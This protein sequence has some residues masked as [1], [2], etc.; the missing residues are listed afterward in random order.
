MS[1]N[2]IEKNFWKL[3]SNAVFG[4]MMEDV[5]RRRD[6][7]LFYKEDKYRAVRTMSGPR[8]KSF[9]IIVP[10]RLCLIEM[11]KRDP[12]V[13]DKC[14]I[15]GQAILDISKYIMYQ[16]HYEVMVPFFNSEAH[17]ERIKLH[18]MDTDSLIY[19][20]QGLDGMSI[21]AEF[22]AMQKVHNCL[23]L[24]DIQGDDHPLFTI[25]KVCQYE[26]KL[27]R[28][29]NKKKLGKFKDVANGIDILEAVFLRPKMYSYSL[30]KPMMLPHPNKKKMKMGKSVPKEYFC[31]QKGIPDK[32]EYTHKDYV[33]TFFGVKEPGNVLFTSFQHT[34]TL[35]VR[36]EVM[37]KKGIVPVDD[38]SF[39]FNA[40]S[41]V[42]Y[43]HPYI[44]EWKSLSIHPSEL[45]SPDMPTEEPSDEKSSTDT[46]SNYWD[47]LLCEM[48]DSDTFN[49]DG[50]LDDAVNM[51]DGEDSN[52]FVSFDSSE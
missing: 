2:D 1:Q 6:I 52:S 41:C 38:K 10:D 18:Y 46:P 21:W 34:K 35:A 47:T 39:W 36:T 5:K 3:M 44:D 45:Y 29:E 7:K 42:R 49:E 22:Y 28:N 9:K 4:K 27:S 48:M 23:D 43:G 40:N 24:S 12:I 37:Q 13:M 20:I 16:F 30:A 14:T 11:E 19:T 8:A 32:V 31:K 17:P 33:D 26:G 15:V 25:E 51:I 50:W